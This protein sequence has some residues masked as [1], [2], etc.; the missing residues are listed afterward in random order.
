M[1][2]EP[3][4]Y[5]HL[6]PRKLKQ[7]TRLLKPFMDPALPLLYLRLVSGE[8]V[9]LAAG[10]SDTWAFARVGYF[11][12][13]T[14]RDAVFAISPTAF[15]GKRDDGTEDVLVTGRDRKLQSIDLHPAIPFVRVDWPFNG[16]PPR[17]HQ[18]EQALGTF[19]LE[20]ILKRA[21][22][23]GAASAYLEGN[24]MTAT[25]GV[26]AIHQ[27]L[28]FAQSMDGWS[29]VVPC[30]QLQ[31]AKASRLQLSVMEDGSLAGTYSA[32]R[33]KMDV[34]IRL[35]SEGPLTAKIKWLLNGV[36][37][38]LETGQLSSLGSSSSLLVLRGRALAEALYGDRE[39]TVAP[40]FSGAVARLDDGHVQLFV[41]TP[42]ALPDS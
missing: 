20:P 28:H 21:E 19:A 39:V 8:S 33:P 11:R 27:R 42:A 17:N 16:K 18:E 6:N 25:N 36:F 24:T 5:V 12:S 29:A 1:A 2:S 4:I 26:A 22:Q 15:K 31:K 7:A 41:A 30:A 37:S 35:P 9:V 10:V 23:L 13:S 40:S 38:D 34:T 14:D 32:G 3:A